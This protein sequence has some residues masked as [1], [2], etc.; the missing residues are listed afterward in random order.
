MRA[1][2]P[3]RL[4]S[5]F[6]ALLYFSLITSA[7]GLAEQLGEICR[8]IVGIVPVVALLM[9]VMAG[10]VYAGGQIMGAETRSRANVWS[11]TMLVGGIIGLVLAA[12][13]P[14]F[15]TIFARASLG[16]QTQAMDI[17]EAINL[18]NP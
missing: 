7:Q 14:Y 6:I 3:F 13:A 8:T 1:R 2:V 5:V 11:T 10:M 15:L 12:S 4:L 18:C 16:T 9:F 17:Y